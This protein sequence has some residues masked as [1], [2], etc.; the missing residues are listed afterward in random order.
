M[1]DTKIC[2]QSKL[3]IFLNAPYNK[4]NKWV[5]VKVMIAEVPQGREKLLLK[6]LLF[7][8]VLALITLN[9][10]GTTRSTTIHTLILLL[11]TFNIPE[12]FSIT[13]TSLWKLADLIA[14]Q[15]ETEHQWSHY[16][17]VK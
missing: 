6:I 15:K 16:V 9:K 14:T 11:C 5:N 12:L 3:L 13:L 1:T 8:A 7:L 4:Y 17:R 10:E 2:T